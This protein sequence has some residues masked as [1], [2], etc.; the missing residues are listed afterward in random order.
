MKNNIL[1][2]C[3]KHWLNW[4][5]VWKEKCVKF[6]L[7]NLPWN[8]LKVCLKLTALLLLK[9]GAG[10]TWGRSLKNGTFIQNKN[11][12]SFWFVFGFVLLGRKYNYCLVT[13]EWLLINQYPA[14]E[15]LMS[16]YIYLQSLR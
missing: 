14:V 10:S 9:T 8:D 7:N 3:I 16:G 1:N 12:S 5:P 13:V 2:F 4:R 15:N 11:V 6:S